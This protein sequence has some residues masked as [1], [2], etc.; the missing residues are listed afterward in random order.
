L[1][2]HCRESRRN[3]FPHELRTTWKQLL[4]GHTLNSKTKNK[5]ITERERK[6]DLH[7]LG[8]LATGRFH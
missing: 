3:A 1:I 5:Y 8:V 4:I 2:S 6:R 7:G